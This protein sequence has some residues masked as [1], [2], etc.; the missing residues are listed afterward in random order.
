M[1]LSSS[2]AIHGRGFYL[3]KEGNVE[4]S[5][6]ISSSAGNIGGW[7]INSTSLTA[8]NITLD[9]TNN[10]GEIELGNA[11]SLNGGGTGIYM[12][13]NGL[14]RVGG[15]RGTGERFIWDGSNFQLTAS[16]LDVSGSEV[17]IQ[18]PT[19]LLGDVQSQ[20]ISG[21]GGDIVISGSNFHLFKGNVTASNVDLSGKIT[22]TSGEFTGTLSSSTGNIGGWTIESDR[23]LSPNNRLE[24]D[25]TSTNQ[26]KVSKASVSGDGADYV[27]MYHQNDSNYGLQG[28]DGGN[29]IF[30]L[31]ST[32]QI[33]GWTIDPT[34]I[35]NSNVTMS[36]ANGGKISLNDDAILLSGSGEGILADGNI[37][38][39]KEGDTTISGQVTM[40]SNVL[41][42]GGIEVGAFPEMPGTENLVG[43]WSFDESEGRHCLDQSGNNNTGSIKGNPTRISG[44]FVSG[45]GLQSSGSIVGNALHFDGSGDCVAITGSMMNA[46]STFCITISSL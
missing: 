6:S 10:K 28:Y 4:I 29:Q 21:S 3:S 2:G 39:N 27:R 23:I 19:F 16:K 13:G 46:G 9:S 35:F 1:I 33:A 36:N 7:T 38:F 34:T 24:L 25:A 43:Y 37:I 22:A 12:N 40:S 17:K 45:S 30:H 8:E 26:V 5:G 41:I 20:F 42:Q 15:N 32:N 44:S 11:T 31:G 18:A 14:F